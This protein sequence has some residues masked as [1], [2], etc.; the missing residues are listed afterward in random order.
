MEKTSP[1][2]FEKLA[3]ERLRNAQLKAE[4][5]AI[6]AKIDRLEREASKA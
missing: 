6:N 4:L 1:S 5:A 3:A 2:I